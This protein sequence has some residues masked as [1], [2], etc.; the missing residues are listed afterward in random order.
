MK[1]SD[2]WYD[3]PQELI[4][5]DPLEKRE[6]SRLLVLDRNAGTISH[7]H[8]FDITDLIRPGDCLVL[9]NSKVMPARVFGTKKT[10]A[11]VEFLLLKNLG[12]DC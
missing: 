4:A 1:K 11:R 6:N 12:G 9:N 5:Q 8:F 2:F 7:R 3:L 10:G